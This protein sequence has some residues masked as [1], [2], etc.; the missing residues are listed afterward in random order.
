VNPDTPPCPRTALEAAQQLA[1]EGKHVHY[2]AE[3]ESVCISQHCTPA[4]P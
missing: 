1:D 4:A 3:A 2:V